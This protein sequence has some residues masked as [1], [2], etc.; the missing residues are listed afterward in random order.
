M[1]INGL[2]DMSNLSL[3]KALVDFAIVNEVLQLLNQAN[4]AVLASRDK[5]MV[6]RNAVRNKDI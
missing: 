1:P 5:G 4:E 3:K 6:L 2:Y